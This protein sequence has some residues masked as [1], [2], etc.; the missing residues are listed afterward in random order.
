M[1]VT[2]DIERPH[3]G[4]VIYVGEGLATGAATPATRGGGTAASQNFWVPHFQTVWPRSTKFGT[5]SQPHSLSRRAGPPP[6]FMSL[7]VFGTP[8]AQTLWCTEFGVVTR[9]GEA[10]F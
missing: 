9:A 1:R 10:C 3:F 4:K 7:P 2:F 6:H 5:E 8:N